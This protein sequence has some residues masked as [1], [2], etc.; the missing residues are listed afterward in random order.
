MLY[1]SLST[2]RIIV[3]ALRWYT[4]NVFHM[5]ELFDM[6]YGICRALANIRQRL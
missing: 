1:L 4:V 5:T 2:R 6:D 3:A